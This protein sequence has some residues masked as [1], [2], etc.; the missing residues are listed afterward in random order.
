MKYICLIYQPPLD[1]TTPDRDELH[2][3]YWQYTQE[4]Q[5]SGKMVGGEALESVSTATTVRVR[6]GETLTT[7]GPFDE[8]MAWA[9]KIPS[10]TFG[11]I[12]VRPIADMG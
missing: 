12:E 3:A 5:A 10:A 4:L 1:E 8:A 2:K 11:S 6:D 9:A 7:D